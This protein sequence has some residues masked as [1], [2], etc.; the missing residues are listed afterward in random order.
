M[1]TV[2]SQFIILTPAQLYRSDVTWL[3]PIMTAFSSDRDLLRL[4]D[5]Y[6]CLLRYRGFL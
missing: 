1:K 6:F 3:E 2:L 4:P 5:Y